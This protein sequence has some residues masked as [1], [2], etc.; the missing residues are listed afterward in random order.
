[1]CDGQVQNGDNASDLGGVQMGQDTVDH[2]G[3]TATHLKGARGVPQQPPTYVPP[4][5]RKRAK[6]G[7]SPSKVGKSD[8]G[9]VASL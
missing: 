9:S 8:L 6:K 7:T 2:V 1:M 3:T 5:E 4:K